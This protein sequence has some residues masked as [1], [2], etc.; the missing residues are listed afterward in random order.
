MTFNV[1]RVIS[2]IYFLNPLISFHTHAFQNFCSSLRFPYNRLNAHSFRYATSH[3]SY[4]SYKQIKS[5]R[6][7]VSTNINNSD[8][9]LNHDCPFKYDEYKEKLQA[10]AFL[11]SMDP[12]ASKKAQDTFSEMFEFYCMDEDGKY[13]DL[14]PTTEIYNLVL[15]ALAYSRQNNYEGAIQAEKILSTMENTSD[16]YL[17]EIGSPPDV[18]SYI[19]VMD[20][21]INRKE[22]AKVEKI[23][24]RLKDRYLEQIQLDDN[25][26]QVSSLK[27]NVSA[28]NR[29]I[30]AWMVNAYQDKRAIKKVETIYEEMI[31][32][33]VKPNTKTFTQRI[34][35]YT[36]SKKIHK[37]SINLAEKAQEIYEE[38]ENLNNNGGENDVNLKPNTSVMNAVIRAYAQSSSNNSKNRSINS[39]IKAETMLHHMILG[40]NNGDD[41][42]SP[43]A[44]SFINTI[45]AWS[46]VNK[47]GSFEKALELL[48]IMSNLYLKTGN[49]NLKPT[50]KVYNAVLNCIARSKESHS[51]NNDKVE[52][53]SKAQLA[54]GILNKLQNSDDEDIKPNLRSYNLVMSACAFSYC[55]NNDDSSSV[56]QKA[57]I[58]KIAIQ[59]FNDLRSA[60]TNNETGEKLFSP[61]YVTYG[62]FL[63]VCGRFMPRNTDHEQGHINSISKRDRIVENLFRKCSD[64]G[65]VDTFVM[66]EFKK[67][68]SVEVIKKM[69]GSL[70][71]E[72]D[73]T[74]SDL[75]IPYEWSRNAFSYY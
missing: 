11:S 32:Q 23:F 35:T 45:N 18:E 57:K 17:E 27:P 64:E 37:R 43:D 36:Y 71:A 69:L 4:R 3:R 2:Y 19:A 68:A 14:R 62:M 41:T 40:Y 66:T 34:L 47:I 63:K 56:K 30:K 60:S 13:D 75:G 8:V 51:S 16:E 5:H 6:K 29:M 72:N 49:T 59:T 46:K 65:M 74:L 20:G 7:S 61:D 21:F 70:D 39:H 44:A 28:Y 25:D 55:N 15:N 10:L 52:N 53:L 1:I 50:I 58:C 12:S 33:N 73:K 9:K 26:N 42:V 24:Q 22:P 67:V 31:Q 38:L 48:N 54:Q